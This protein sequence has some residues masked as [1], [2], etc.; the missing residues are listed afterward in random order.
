VE[1]KHYTLDEME[2]YIERMNLLRGTV[3]FSCGDEM[4]QQAVEMLRS[5]SAT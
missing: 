3:P 5:Q 2:Q 4:L 1:E